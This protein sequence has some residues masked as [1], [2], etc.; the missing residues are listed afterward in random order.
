MFCDT[1]TVLSKSKNPNTHK[2]EWRKI[3][4]TGCNWSAKTVRNVSGSTASIS[5][6]LSCRIPYNGAQIAINLGDYAVK[7]EIKEEITSDNIVKVV[8]SYRPNA[9]MIKSFKDN[10]ADRLKHYHIEGV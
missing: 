7:G 3:V 9:F 6:T 4:L 2:D 8:N 5:Y 1:I 10:T